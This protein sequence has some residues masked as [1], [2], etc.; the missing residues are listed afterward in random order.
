MAALLATLGDLAFGLFAAGVLFGF[1]NLAAKW[2]EGSRYYARRLRFERERPVDL[3]R[4]IRQH[5]SSVRGR[6]RAA[7]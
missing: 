2:F 3:E 7:R 6:G 4:A 1:F 5:E